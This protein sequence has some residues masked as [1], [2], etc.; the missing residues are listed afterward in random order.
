MKSAVKGIAL[1]ATGANSRSVLKVDSKKLFRPAA[2]ADFSIHAI[3]DDS[4]VNSPDKKPPASMSSIA[5]VRRHLATFSYT[6]N[7]LL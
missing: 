7:V 3:E 6:M 4:D 1:L 2:V 5:T